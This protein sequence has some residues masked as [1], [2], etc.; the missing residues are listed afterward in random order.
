MGAAY[1]KACFFNK[2]LV[3]QAWDHDKDRAVVS[4]A[5]HYSFF[6][7]GGLCGRNLPGL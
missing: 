5:G 3:F 6:C 4:G 1:E 2:R 7:H